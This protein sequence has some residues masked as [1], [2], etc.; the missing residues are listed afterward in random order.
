M[1][2]GCARRKSTRV[3]LVMQT[4]VRDS[5]KV[6]TREL[7]VYTTC[8][9]LLS[10]RHVL[11]DRRLQESA[12]KRVLLIYATCVSQETQ[13]HAK[14]KTSFLAVAC[15]VCGVLLVYRQE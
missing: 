7:L 1:L 14:D 6:H 9:S 10:S 4:C 3:S 5:R 15:S 13:K 11:R 12:Y 2:H 8:V